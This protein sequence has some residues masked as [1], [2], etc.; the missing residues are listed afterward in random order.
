MKK[1]ETPEIGDQEVGH[2][3]TFRY[4]LDGVRYFGLPVM[5]II[6]IFLAGGVGFFVAYSIGGRFYGFVWIALVIL[7]CPLMSMYFA[8]DRMLIR[9]WYMRLRGKFDFEVSGM[10]DCRKTVKFLDAGDWSNWR[11]DGVPYV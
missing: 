10:E 4:V 2:H 3:Y 7:A 11:D 8:A 9:F 1:Q 6:G 5:W